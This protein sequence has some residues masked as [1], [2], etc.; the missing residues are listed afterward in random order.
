[1]TEETLCR[2]QSAG[3]PNFSDGD[4]RNTEYDSGNDWNSTNMRGLAQAA[5]GFILA[6]SVPVWGDLQKKNEGKQRQGERQ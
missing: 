1:V 6:T 2:N 3:R 4:Q 5:G